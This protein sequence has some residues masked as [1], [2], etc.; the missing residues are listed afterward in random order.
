MKKRFDNHQTIFVNI[1]GHMPALMFFIKSAEETKD[2]IV[3]RMDEH[4]GYYGCVGEALESQAYATQD[5][6]LRAAGFPVRGD[7]VEYQGTEYTLDY[8]TWNEDTGLPTRCGIT[9][10]PGAWPVEV[11]WQEIR[12]TA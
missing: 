10:K 9:M 8:M 2:G 11:P 12:Y 3:Y 5:E 1:P 4:M 7:K 6:A